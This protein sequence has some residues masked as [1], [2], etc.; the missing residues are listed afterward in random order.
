[1]QEVKLITFIEGN[2]AVN[3]Y[4][5]GLENSFFDITPKAQAIKEK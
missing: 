2:P 3:L 4:D 1:M 5:F